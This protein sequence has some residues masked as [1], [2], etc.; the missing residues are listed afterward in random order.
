MG[1]AC[2]RM[3]GIQFVLYK[4]RPPLYII[5][6]QR[7]L[8]AQQGE[9]RRARGETTRLTARAC[10]P[11]ALLLLRPQRRRLSSARPFLRHQLSRRR[12]RRAAKKRALVHDRQVNNVLTMAINMSI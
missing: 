12:R 6:K 4:A 8:S 11:A 9:T 2:S 1:I 5:R 10:S 3:N 7:R